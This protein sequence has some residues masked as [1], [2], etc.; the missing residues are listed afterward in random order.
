MKRKTAAMTFR[1]ASA[2]PCIPTRLDKPS[3]KTLAARAKRKVFN[4]VLST[5][6]LSPVLRI[7]VSTRKMQPSLRLTRTA[8]FASVQVVDRTPKMASARLQHVQLAR[9]ARF[10]SSLLVQRLWKTHAKPCL[11]LTLDTTKSNAQYCLA[12]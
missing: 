3:A 1:L 8:C 12:L 4:L 6:V 11:S 2:Q 7:C 9:K 5:M 10:L